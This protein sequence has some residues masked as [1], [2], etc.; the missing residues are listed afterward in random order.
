MNRDV[1]LYRAE[2][3]KS[4]E[5]FVSDFHD[6][7]KKYDFVINNFENMDMKQTFREHG[8]IVPDEFDLQRVQV[9]KPTKAEASR[10]AN[11]ER[12]SLLP[13]FV[14]VFTKDDETHIRYLSYSINEILELVPDD[15]KFPESVSQTFEKIRSMIDE[16]K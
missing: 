15:P 6:V 3:E 12:A 1:D 11:P 5:Q 14:M 13:K 7:G 16:A 4:V 10:T 8:G 9:C 2:S